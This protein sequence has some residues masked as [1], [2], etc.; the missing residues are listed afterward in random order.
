M[1]ANFRKMLRYRQK[2]EENVGKIW[3]RP[4]TGLKLQLPQAIRIK[5]D[6]DDVVHGIIGT[7]IGPDTLYI[8]HSYFNR[9]WDRGT[10]RVLRGAIHL[11]H[12]RDV[13]PSRKLFH[14]WGIL[15][16]PW[17]KTGKHIVL[18]A[19]SHYMDDWYG[20]DLTGNMLAE[21]RKFTDRPIRVKQKHG[22]ISLD[23]ALED[24]WAVA[25]PVSVGAVHACMNG[26]PVI[27]TPRCPSW[28]MSTPM[29]MIE[30]PLMPDREKWLASLASVCHHCERIEETNWRTYLR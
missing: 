3:L 19:T 24:A 7:R 11:T 27:S 4:S 21:L 20:E 14:Q 23:E 9:G 26:Y 12:V 28:P 8:D 22:D 6:Q 2:S 1:T 13:E 17:R 16:R 18:L 29:D 25:T 30:D 10:F 5:S 15:P